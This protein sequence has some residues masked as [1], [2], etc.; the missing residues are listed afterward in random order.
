MTK[1]P[2]YVHCRP[3]R[4]LD[5]LHNRQRARSGDL[6]LSWAQKGG[7]ERSNI[8]EFFSRVYLS[9]VKAPFCGYRVEQR[10]SFD[11]GEVLPAWSAM[12]HESR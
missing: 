5:I 8:I 12:V 1:S 6:L 4:T 2:D 10:C 7:D 9:L 3:G 11:I